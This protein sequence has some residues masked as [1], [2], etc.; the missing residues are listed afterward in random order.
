MLNG[1]SFYRDVC[2]IRFYGYS[3]A[4][5]PA[6]IAK[7][8]NCRKVKELNA[9]QNLT[10]PPAHPCS[11]GRDPL[12]FTFTHTDPCSHVQSPWGWIVATTPVVNSR[13][14]CK[15]FQRHRVP[16]QSLAITQCCWKSGCYCINHTR[17][18]PVARKLPL[19]L[20]GEPTGCSHVSYHQRIQRELKPPWIGKT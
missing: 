12:V 18:I 15:D 13:Q 11:Q 10:F 8:F 6:P 17:S 14:L 9:K 16:V 4:A 1:T 5:L 3:S 19:A 2:K 7:R 20:E